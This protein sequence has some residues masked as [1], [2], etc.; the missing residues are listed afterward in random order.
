[1]ARRHRRQKRSDDGRCIRPGVLVVDKPKGITSFDVVARVRRILGERRVGHTG[2]L[3]PLATG[4]MLVCVGEATKLVP[5][6]TASDKRYRATVRLG[7]ETDSYDAEGQVTA[8]AA[9]DALAA[10]DADEIREALRAFEG[11]VEQRPPVFSAIRVD[12]ERLHRRARAGEVVQAPLRMVVIREVALVDV[13]LPDVVI[14]VHCGKGTYIRSIAADL[15]RA[16][17]VGGHITSLRRLAVGRFGIEDAGELETWA[18]NPALAMAAMIPMADAVADLPA[19]ELDGPALADIRCGR[20]RRFDGVAVG[21][22]RA[23]TRDGRLVAI[24]EHDG[25]GPARVVR[26]FAADELEGPSAET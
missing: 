12:G 5:F 21:R 18:A 15:G 23:L 19:V 11:E 24:L 26:G 6:L 4:V 25:C 8:R 1:M 10:V 20:K 17:G 3:D 2:T 7:V 16:L 13:A 22:F 9:P 14:D